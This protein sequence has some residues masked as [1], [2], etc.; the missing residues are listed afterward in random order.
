MDRDTLSRLCCSLISRLCSVFSPRLV[1]VVCNTAS[2]SALPALRKAFPDLPFVGTVPAV[3]PA[4]LSSRKGHIGVLGTSRTIGDPYIARLAARY[5]PDC[6]VTG[7][8]AP[9]LVKFVER[10]WDRADQEE[11][12]RV[13]APYI[14]AFRR[15][16]ADALVL[17]CTHFLFLLEE[18]KFAAGGDMTIHESVEGVSRRIEALLDEGEP[19]SA[20]AASGGEPPRLLVVT[21]NAEEEL[22]R[23]RAER[24]GLVFCALQGETP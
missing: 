13:V 18:F 20:P 9:E 19:R 22:W 4:V 3:K 7:I 17:G 11:R 2:V 16:G 15:A 12:R 14:E 23:R 24:F 10:R 6:A 8:A 21:G 1:A 5:A